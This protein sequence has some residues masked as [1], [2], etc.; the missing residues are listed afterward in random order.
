MKVSREQYADYLRSR[1]W[2]E[3]TMVRLVS[4]GR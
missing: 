2:A 1:E 3:R 4:D